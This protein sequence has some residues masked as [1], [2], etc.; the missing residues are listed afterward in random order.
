MGDGASSVVDGSVVGLGGEL[1]NDVLGGD[2]L[3][4]AVRVGGLVVV[5]RPG[6]TATGPGDGE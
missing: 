5:G 3:V 4:G 2:V 6:T 1:G